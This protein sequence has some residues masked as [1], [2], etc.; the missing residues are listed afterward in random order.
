MQIERLKGD[1]L[2]LQATEFPEYAQLKKRREHWPRHLRI[3]DAKHQGATHSEIADQF[4]TDGQVDE[5]SLYKDT[6]NKET[7]KS[8]HKA[9]V[10]QWYAQAFGVMGKAARLL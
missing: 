1:L 2:M 5:A 7:A 4:T 8:R 10:S 6:G 9:I 3:I